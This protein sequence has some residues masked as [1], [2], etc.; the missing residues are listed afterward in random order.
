MEIKY[1]DFINE[2]IQ[3]S[4][5]RNAMAYV[6]RVCRS[7]KKYASKLTKEKYRYL[8]EKLKCFPEEGIY[9]FNAERVEINE[10]L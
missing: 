5:S 1:D 10:I 9:D 3:I 2:N 8:I 7:P 4:E 6:I